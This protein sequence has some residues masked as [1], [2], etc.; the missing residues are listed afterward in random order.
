MIFDSLGNVAKKSTPP[1][2]P[3]VGGKKGIELI[4]NAQ[5]LVTVYVTWFNSASGKR[6]SLN[7]AALI[8][9][10][11][12]EEGGREVENG[13]RVIRWFSLSYCILLSI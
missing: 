12:G 7:H 13:N 1:P 6:E 10:V 3:P 5:G 9:K 2:P 11:S 8:E 4:Y